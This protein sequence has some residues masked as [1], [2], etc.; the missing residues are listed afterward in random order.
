MDIQAIKG[1]ENEKK[2]A[3]EEAM[4]RKSNAVQKRKEV[5]QLDRLLG[6][7]ESAGEELAIVNVAL[8]MKDAMEWKIK[9]HQARLTAAEHV[10]E[11][12]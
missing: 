8:R 7:P 6:E 10:N 9:E 2:E 1:V 5:D 11:M 3:L 12:E 4:R